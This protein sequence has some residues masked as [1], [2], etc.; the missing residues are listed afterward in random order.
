MSW[1]KHFTVYKFANQQ[2]S[3]SSGPTTGRYSKFQIICQKFIA[4]NQTGLN[5]IFNMIKWTQI[6]KLMRH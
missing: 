1:K 6:L 3:Q 5:D 2:G 4:D